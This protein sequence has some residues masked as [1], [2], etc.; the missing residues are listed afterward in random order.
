MDLLISTFILSNNKIN[1]ES[2]LDKGEKAAIEYINNF[3][4]EK[5]VVDSIRNAIIAG[6]FV[7]GIFSKVRAIS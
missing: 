5:L 6:V 4:V 2:Y 7:I 3:D 1:L